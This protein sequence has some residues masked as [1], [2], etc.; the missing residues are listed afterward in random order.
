MEVAPKKA[1]ERRETAAR[2][3]RV[4]RWLEDSGNAALMGRELPLDEVLAIDDRI[5]WWAEE[6]RRAGLDGGTDE[7][8]ARAYLDLLLNKDSRPGVSPAAGGQ[9]GT[10]GTAPAGF[11]SRVTLTV[12]LTTVT[13][14]ADRPGELGG[15]GPGRPLASPR[16][17]PRRRGQPQDNMVPDRHRPAR[18]RSRPRLRPPRTQTP[19]AT[20]RPRPA[21]LH[22]H[23][24]QPGRPARWVRQLAAAHPRTR[25]GPDHQPGARSP[26][27]PATTATKPAATIPGSSSGTCPRSGTPPAPAPSAGGPPPGPTS[28]TTPRTKQADERVSVTA[29]RSVGTTTGSNSTPSGRSTSSRTVPSGGPPLQGG[30]TPP[31]PPGTPSD[32][33]GPCG[34]GHGRHRRPR[35]QPLYPM[36]AYETDSIRNMDEVD[37]PGRYRPYLW[38]TWSWPVTSTSAT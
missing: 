3:A 35:Q 6:L 34:P 33:P 27:T 8:R 23:P 11:A 9:S 5:T 22:L 12:P 26:P 24:R 18:P 17:R 14:L 31:N 4:E 16:P 36:L 1:K 38:K 21:R 2:F 37:H 29:G 20:R 13:G 30:P 15:T 19:Q 32:P 10:P 7:I 25:A 28:S